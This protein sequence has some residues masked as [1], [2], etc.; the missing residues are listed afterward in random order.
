MIGGDLDDPDDPTGN[1]GAKASLCQGVGPFG[2]IEHIC[3]DDPGDGFTSYPDIRIIS[4]TG[5]NFEG[6]PV[7]SVVRD[8]VDPAIDPDKLLQV[9][10][11]VGLKQTG[12]YRGRPYYGSVFYQDGVKYAGW[13]ETAGELVP[14]YNTLQESIDAEVTTPASAI[15]RQG[16][17]SSSNDKRLNLPG[18]PENLT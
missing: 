9:T 3:I 13:Y 15:L 5:V 18:T 17:D 8:P 11:L 4:E 16:S 1:T 10:D 2:K 7:F 12:Y 6:T 14:I